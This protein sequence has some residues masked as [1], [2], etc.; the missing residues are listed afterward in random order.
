LY[1]FMALD[2]YDIDMNN[3]MIYRERERERERE[4]DREVGAL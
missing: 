2:L 4:S 3:S 1:E